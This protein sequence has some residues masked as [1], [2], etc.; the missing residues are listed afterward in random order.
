VLKR[1]DPNR[2]VTASHAGDI[3]S[4][5]LKRCVLDVQVDFISPHRPRNAKSPGQTEKRSQEYLSEMISGVR[6]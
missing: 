6:A 3:P 5:D 4:D 1:V 2:L